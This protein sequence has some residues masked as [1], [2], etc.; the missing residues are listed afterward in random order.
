[1]SRY[2]VDSAQVATAAASVQ[3]RAG[4]IRSEVAAMHR[5]LADLQGSWRGAAATAFAGV[6]ADWSATEA[7][8]D[9]SLEQ[10]VAA[11]QSAAR[12]YAEAEA[13]ASRLFSV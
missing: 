13:Q 2:E 12:A 11:M 5:Q 4:T 6:L 10:I 8:L 3:A 1:M 7:R 9:A